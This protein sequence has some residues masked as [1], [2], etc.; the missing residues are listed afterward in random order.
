MPA[1]RLDTDTLTEVLKAKDPQVVGHAASDVLVARPVDRFLRDEADLA[2]ASRDLDHQPGELEDRGLLGGSDV[3]DLAVGP[4][5]RAG[6]DDRANRVVDVGEAARLQ[7]VAVDHGR[8]PA[9]Q[10]GGEQADHPAVGRARI[11]ARPEHVEVAERQRLHPVQAREH[12]QEQLA[13]QLGDGVG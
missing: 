6:G 13:G 11:L 8:A 2:P 3:E 1:A 7:A 12:A 4:G 10:R 5:E 9:Q